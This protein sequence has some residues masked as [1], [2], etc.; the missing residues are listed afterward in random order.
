VCCPLCTLRIAAVASQCTFFGSVQ[1]GFYHHV[2]A[3]A[4]MW[5]VVCVFVGP[6]EGL[7]ER[8]ADDGN[9]VDQMVCFQEVDVLAVI[10]REMHATGVSLGL[11]TEVNRLSFTCLAS[12]SLSPTC[13]PWQ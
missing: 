7:V 12:A 1:V 6:V 5:G 9:A 4:R 11:Y 8:L 13:G 2:D 3:V 10:G